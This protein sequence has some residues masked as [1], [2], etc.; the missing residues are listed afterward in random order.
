MQ[1]NLKN[2]IK[3][4]GFWISLLSILFLIAKQILNK[5]GIVVDEYFITE[6]ISAICF[7]LITLGVISNPESGKGYN[8]IKKDVAE[9]INNPTLPKTEQEKSETTK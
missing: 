1:L 7:L 3:N 4:Y 6:I 9:N 2:K 5:C 8:D